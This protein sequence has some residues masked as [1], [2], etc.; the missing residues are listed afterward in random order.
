MSH[1]RPHEGP[2]DPPPQQEPGSGSPPPTYGSPPPA[3]GSALPSYESPPSGGYG[4]P[5]PGGYGAPPGHAEF[6]VGDAFSYGWR[7]FW[8]N[9]GTIAVA[10]LVYV[11]IFI[12]LQALSYSVTPGQGGDDAGTV[13]TFLGSLVVTVLSTI[14]S[15]VAQAGIARGVLDITRGRPLEVATMF[16]FDNIVTVIIA[17]IL[18]G[19]ATAIG[20]VLLIVPGLIVVFFSQFTV[21][22][23]VDR[24]L[25]VLDS[26]KASFRLVGRNFGPMVLFFL[27][28][29]LAYLAGAIVLIVGLLVAVP[30]VYIAQGYAYR[31]LQGEPVAP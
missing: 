17:S 4:A 27:A 22:F 3:Y 9:V 23:I 20:F 16:K 25:G 19:I 14:I 8:P 5:P 26:I 18:I 15:A 29:L 13:A 11:G 6:R 31:T 7:K 24:Q 2:D 21:W 10:A 1:D 12:V 30:V 28:S